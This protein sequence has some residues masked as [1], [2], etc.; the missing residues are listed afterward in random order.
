ME[1]D[2]TTLVRLSLDKFRAGDPTGRDELTHLALERLNTLAHRMLRGDFPRVGRWEET[3]DIAQEAAVRFLSALTAVRPETPSHFFALMGTQIRRT[4][5]DLARKHYGRE[6]HGANL[7]SVTDVG[8]AAAGREATPDVAAELG[9]VNR[10]IDELPP[11]QRAVIDLIDYGGLTQEEAAAE[12][13]V[14]VDTIRRQRLRAL[15]TLGSKFQA[16]G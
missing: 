13:G 7:A 1:S 16:G 3:S 2:T 8:G 10:L 11:E 14:H 6:G 4:L 5:H 12:L 9:E 15:R